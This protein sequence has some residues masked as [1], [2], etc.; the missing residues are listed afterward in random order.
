VERLGQ[1]FIRTG[2]RGTV[3][4]SKLPNENKNYILGLI[5]MAL[6]D[7]KAKQAYHKKS[8][9]ISSLAF[10][11]TALQML[12]IKGRDYKYPTSN[13]LLYG[14]LNFYRSRTAGPVLPFLLYALFGTPSTQ[15]S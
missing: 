15:N 6:R 7:F 14:L 11:F 8:Q 5:D 9:T 1:C 13:H 10:I 3:E 4:V 2:S 12:I